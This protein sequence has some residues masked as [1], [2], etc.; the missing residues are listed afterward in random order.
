MPAALE[1]DPILFQAQDESA[2]SAGDVAN[3]LPEDAF[4]SARG[5]VNGLVA[6]LIFWAVAIYLLMK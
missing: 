4:S 5:M 6:G 1:H 3:E 2:E